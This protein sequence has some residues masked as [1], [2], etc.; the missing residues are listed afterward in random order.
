MRKLVL[1]MVAHTFDPSPQEAEASDLLVG[2]QPGLHSE[3]RTAR[4]MLRDPI[5]KPKH[6]KGGLGDSL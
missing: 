3:F 5:K 1:G 6:R 4:A 2:G